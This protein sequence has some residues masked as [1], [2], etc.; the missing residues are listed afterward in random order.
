MI[1]RVLTVSVVGVFFQLWGIILMGVLLSYLTI[2][3]L[4]DSVTDK[5]KRKISFYF[6]LVLNT[7]ILLV[8]LVLYYLDPLDNWNKL[9]IREFPYAVL[10]IIISVISTGVI[11]W[12]LDYFH[13][14]FLGSSVFNVM[15]DVGNVV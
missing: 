3:N 9:E 1:F 12:T 8:I 5:L 14:L 4:Q 10:I 11:S 2:T 15:L 6:S 7:I 13:G